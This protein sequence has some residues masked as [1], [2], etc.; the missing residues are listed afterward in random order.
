LICETI[1]R[2]KPA[3]KEISEAEAFAN[4]MSAESGMIYKLDALTFTENSYEG[5]AYILHY[6]DS[7]L[8]GL[9]VLNGFGREETEITFIS[10]TETTVRAMFDALMQSGKV[11]SLLAISN[12]GD[13]RLV[14][15]LKD[16]GFVFS[17]TE[18]RMAFC[19]EKFDKAYFLANKKFKLFIKPATPEDMEIIFELDAAAFGREEAQKPMPQD[20]PGTRIAY[21][22]GEAAG[23]LRIDAAFGVFGIYAFSIKPD[24]HGK[25]LGREF[26]GEILFDLSEKS[27]KKIFLEVASDNSRAIKLYE[28]L[29]FQTE[30]IFDYWRLI[31]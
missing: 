28:G 7:S 31:R 2:E 25:G 8:S 14:Q 26:L 23:K 12:R 17:A 11:K 24:C 1:L 29:A 15:W 18:Y 27:F 13:K 22:N 3:K 16:W 4:S 10:R 9:A 21:L 6:E 5:A 20:L 30:A 19:K